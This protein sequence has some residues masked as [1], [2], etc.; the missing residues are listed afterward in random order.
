MEIVLTNPVLPFDPQTLLLS[1]DTAIM[2]GKEKADAYKT[3]LPYPHAGFDNFL[4]PEILERVIQELGELPDSETSFDR[5]QERLKTSYAPERL[6]TYTKNLFY[7]LNAKP[8]VR[9]LEELTGIDGLIPDPYFSG[10]GIH[11]AVR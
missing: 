5:A 7:A 4:P 6:G 3:A 11:L 8:F 1:T 10:G 9:F 2:A